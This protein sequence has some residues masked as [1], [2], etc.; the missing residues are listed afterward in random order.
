MNDILRLYNKKIKERLRESPLQDQLSYNDFMR[1][2]TQID[3]AQM[4]VNEELEASIE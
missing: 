4:D 1:L 3:L 2:I